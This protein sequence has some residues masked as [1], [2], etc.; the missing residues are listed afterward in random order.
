MQVAVES[1]STKT[2]STGSGESSPRRQVLQNVPS[3]L[4]KQIICQN[5]EASF[6]FSQQSFNSRLQTDWVVGLF[7][8]DILLMVHTTA[9]AYG[10]SSGNTKHP[11]GVCP[12]CPDDTDDTMA[13]AGNASTCCGV[14]FEKNWLHT[15]QG[16]WPP[17]TLGGGTTPSQVKWLVLSDNEVLAP[18]DALPAAAMAVVAAAGPRTIV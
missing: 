10:P 1:Q 8:R 2:L 12:G 6:H 3:N 18:S 14:A 15:A 5:R 11:G 7:S 9:G 13:A 4:S 17:S 16:V